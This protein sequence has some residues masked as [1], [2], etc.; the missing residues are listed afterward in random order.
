MIF[1]NKEDSKERIRTHTDIKSRQD[2]NFM[3]F[4]KTSTPNI[5]IRIN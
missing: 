4:R 2:F 5:V 3:I 1:F